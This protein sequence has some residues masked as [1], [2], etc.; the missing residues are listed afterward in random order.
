MEKLVVT[1]FFLWSFFH[2]INFGK[3]A[4]T[5]KSGTS[6]ILFFSEKLL[7]DYVES[8]RLLRA[9]SGKKNVGEVIAFVGK[10][11]FFFIHVHY[12]P[13]GCGTNK[14]KIQ[15]LWLSLV[16]VSVCFDVEHMCVKM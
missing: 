3:I 10:I 13:I 8:L 16:Y 1:F 2:P 5:F 6:I 4:R 14:W 15:I 11:C 9:F 7:L 12:K